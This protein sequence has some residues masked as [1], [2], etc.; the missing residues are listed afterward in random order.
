MKQFHIH[1]SVKN[2]AESQTFYTQLFGQEPTVSKTD[3]AKWRLDDPAI[4]FAI[5]AR[6]HET[7]LNHLGF[8]VDTDDGLQ[9]LEQQALAAVG[10]AVIQQGETTC[11]YAKSDKHWT[12]DPSGIAWEHYRTMESAQTFSEDNAATESTACCTPSFGSSCCS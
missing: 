10:D 6:G 8:Q 3:Y 9:Q 2:L 11:C 1:L 7:G 5:S 4:N 12:I